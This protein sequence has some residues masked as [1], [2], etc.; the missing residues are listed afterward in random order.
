[1]SRSDSPIY[2]KMC[3]PLTETITEAADDIVCEAVL[4]YLKTCRVGGMPK[5]LSDQI[6][7]AIRD[8]ASM[9]YFSGA[10]AREARIRIDKA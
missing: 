10:L 7:G 8:A 2:T 3:L 6:E 9:R 4:Q 1:M 5:E